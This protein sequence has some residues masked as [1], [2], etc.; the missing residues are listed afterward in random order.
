MKTLLFIASLAAVLSAM[1]V[2]AQQGPAGV[3][4]APGLAPAPPPPAPIAAPQAAQAK[5]QAPHHQADC[6]KARNVAQCK[7]RQEVQRKV[8]EA[9][10]GK[11]GKQR[12]QC[13]KN[14]T[15]TAECST[16]ADPARCERYRKARELCS[17]KLGSEHQ[18]CLRD[19]LTTKK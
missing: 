18:Q 5:T 10:Q 15:R 1:P 19:N 7:A 13:V 3:P 11:S 8:T 9:C 2:V 14:E 4:G 6:S 17:V 16:S 12:K